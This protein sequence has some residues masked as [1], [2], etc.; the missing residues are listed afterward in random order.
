MKARVVLKNPMSAK[1]INFLL[2][3]FVVACAT[4]AKKLEK[5]F[6]WTAQYQ[7][8]TYHF[9]GTM[10]AGFSIRSLPETILNDLKEA[11]IVAVEITP[12]ILKDANK[13]ETEKANKFVNKAYDYYPDLKSKLKP[14]TWEHLSYTLNQDEVKKYLKDLNVPHANNHIHPAMILIVTT[15]FL[16]KKATYLF[17]PDLFGQDTTY[18]R[19][20]VLEERNSIM[21]SEI[22]YYCQQVKKP[23]IPMD[24]P[25]L[26][27][28][29]IDSFKGDVGIGLI[30]K[31]YNKSSDAREEMKKLENVQEMYQTGDEAGMVKMLSELKELKTPLLSQRN[32]HWFKVLSVLKEKDIFVAAGTLHFVGDQ[33]LIKLFEKAGA[34]V[35]RQN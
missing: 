14:K 27:S 32:Q 2:L 10:H 17:H 24:T 15:Y 13:L 7:N 1:Y 30:E 6:Y 29:A 25:Q 23:V 3:L 8:K 11:D 4:P 34:K 33:S 20:S 19:K 35:V 9:L 18:S 31:I 5:P 28:A 21:D 22:Y 16:E 12:D 26:V